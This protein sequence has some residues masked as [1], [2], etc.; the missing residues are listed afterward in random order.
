M[1]PSRVAPSKGRASARV[2]F[3]CAHLLR[4]VRYF[5]GG[6]G[7][8]RTLPSTGFGAGLA[9]KIAPA[10]PR[11]NASMLGGGRGRGV[12]AAAQPRS[13]AHANFARFRGGRGDRSAVVAVPRR[14]EDVKKRGRHVATR[15]RATEPKANRQPTANWTASE[16]RRRSCAAGACALV[17]P[18]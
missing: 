5:G 12:H 17:F 9:A 2:K 18:L 10:A 1:G 6:H 7:G 11:Q 14:G 4:R 13:P 8:T 15:L 3:R 16:S